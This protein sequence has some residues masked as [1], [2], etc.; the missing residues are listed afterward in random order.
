MF[1]HCESIRDVKRPSLHVPKRL[2]GAEDVEESEERFLN[3]VSRSSVRDAEPSNETEQDL[4]VSPFELSHGVSVR[5]KV[6]HRDNGGRFTT[7]EIKVVVR[8]EHQKADAARRQNAQSLPP[9][10]A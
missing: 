1:V 7:P 5:A 6:A 2:P 3:H 10:G 4:T 8:H 9:A